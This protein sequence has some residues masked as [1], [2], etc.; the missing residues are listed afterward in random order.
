MK[1]NNIQL[2]FLWVLLAFL[3]SGCNPIK[4]LFGDSFYKDHG[5]L[6]GD[7]RFP[8]LKPY[9]M[10]YGTKASGWYT[11]LHLGKE[12]SSIYFLFTIYD[13]EKVAVENEIIMLYSPSARIDVHNNSINGKPYYWFII[14]PDKKMEVGFDNENDF[15]TY[16]HKFG[17]N[18]PQWLLPL[19]LHKQ[20]D[21]TWCVPWSPIC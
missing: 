2:S 3:L 5:G 12:D 13:I 10:Q 11:D 14:I 9:N 4:Y 7:A 17:I 15:L 19:D 6:F 1:K 18:E 21:N 16:V 8:L 20:F